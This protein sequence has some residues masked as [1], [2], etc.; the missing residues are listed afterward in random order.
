MKRRIAAILVAIALLGGGGD[1]KASPFLVCDVRHRGFAAAGSDHL[2]GFSPVWIGDGT[3]FVM[4][5]TEVSPDQCS[6]WNEWMV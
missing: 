1:A 3:G 4:V 2:Y 5:G 6:V